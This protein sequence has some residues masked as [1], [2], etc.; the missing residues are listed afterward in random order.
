MPPSNK[1]VKTILFIGSK[2]Y[3]NAKMTKMLD[4]ITENTVRHNMSL[5]DRNNGTHCDKLYLCNHLHWNIVKRKLCE[6][7][8]LSVYEK[9][10]KRDSIVDFVANFDK[11]KYASIE[12]MDGTNTSHTTKINNFLKSVSMDSSLRFTKQ[13]RTGMLSLLLTIIK[14]K[15]EVERGDVE[16]L[17][18]GYSVTNEVRLSSYVKDDVCVRVHTTNLH[19]SAAEEVKVLRWLHANKFVD[20]TL[21]MI[22]DTEDLSIATSIVGLEPSLRVMNIIEE[23]R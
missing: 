21:C 12:L 3:V 1:T 4:S 7:N 16:I 13:I 15:K 11:E 6:S 10:Y 17:V 23:H 2:P 19:H 14:H 18:F 8:M 9:Q 22:E 5:P 20:A